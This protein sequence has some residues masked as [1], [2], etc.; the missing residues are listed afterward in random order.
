MTHLD[1]SIA[2]LKGVSTGDAIG[3]QTETLARE[4]ISAWYPRGVQGFHGQPGA[5]IPRYT[6]K[7]YEWKVGET[8]D[9][10]EQTLAIAHA[11][12]K[13]PDAS[14]VGFGEELLKCRKAN[15][16][17]L[18]LG[19]FQQHGG[20]A[21][22]SSDGDGC[23][24]AMRMAPIGI[25]YSHKNLSTLVEAAFQAS[26][27]THGGQLAICAASAVAAAVSAAVDGQAP[28]T[29]LGAAVAAATLAEHYCPPSAS[30]SVAEL[31]RQMYDTLSTQRNL[32]ARLSLPDCFPDRTEVIV[33]LAISL[34]LVTQ[35]ARE[36]IL[37]AANRGGDTDSVAAIGAGIAGALAPA[38]VDDIWYDAV[39]QVN[40]NDVTEVARRLSMLRR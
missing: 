22:R 8:T 11:L 39:V 17:T 35:S 15:R 2:C 9:D 24:A 7:R 25:V 36:T 5:V 26:V 19:R 14:H 29:I 27:P 13:N 6:G 28:A 31:L 40:Q 10:T 16:L 38:S 3:K 34:A 37:L 30:K 4:Q 1:R 20:P 12:L 21:F 23:G 18:S 33:P 32:E